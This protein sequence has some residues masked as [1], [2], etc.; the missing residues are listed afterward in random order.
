VLHLYLVTDGSGSWAMVHEGPLPEEPA[1]ASGRL[2]A[3]LGRFERRETALEALDL[4]REALGT[5]PAEKSPEERARSCDFALL[6]LHP[7]DHLSRR[8]IRRA[9]PGSTRPR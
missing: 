5:L 7:S 4:A 2:F 1:G 8:A 3:L 9:R 6:G